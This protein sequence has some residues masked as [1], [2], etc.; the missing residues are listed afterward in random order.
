MRI[1]LGPVW[2]LPGYLINRI[3]PSSLPVA[4]G[5]SLLVGVGGVAQAV[6]QEVERHDGDDHERGGNQ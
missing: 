5:G 2:S 6:A 1:L 3:I 4:R